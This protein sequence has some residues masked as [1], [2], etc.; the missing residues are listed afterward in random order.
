MV[1]WICGC[2]NH[3]YEGQTVPVSAKGKKSKEDFLF[4]GKNESHNSLQRLFCSQLLQRQCSTEQQERHRQAPSLGTTSQAATALN[5]VCEYLCFIS[6]Y[7]LH[8]F[9]KICPKVI[10]SFG[11]QKGFIGTPYFWIVGETCTVFY[12][13]YLLYNSNNFEKRL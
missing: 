5:C 2:G 6:I 9:S 10:A 7:F 8:P 13:C 3:G 12:Q 1:S 11:F 4:Y